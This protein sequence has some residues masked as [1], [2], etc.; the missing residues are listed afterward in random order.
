MPTNA[1]RLSRPVGFRGVFRTDRE[2]C[3]V[4]SESAGVARMIPAAVAVPLSPDDVSTLM[5]WAAANRVSLVPRG[6]GSSMGGGAVGA[7]VIV[8]LLRLDTV[9]L[10]DVNAR[11]V[12]VAAAVTRDRAE[13]AANEAGLIFPVDPSSGAFATIGGMCATNAAGARTVKYGAMRSWV[14]AVDCIFAD[15]SRARL[16]RGAAA[17]P[18]AP[19]TRFLRDVA[20]EIAKANPALLRHA[21]VRKESSGYGLAAYRESQDLVDLLIGSEGT[22]G[23]IIGAELKLAPLPAATAGVLAG[24]PDLEGAAAAAGRLA[25]A[26]ASAVELLDRSFIE[27]AASAGDPLPIAL[28]KG[29]EAVLIVEVESATEAAA[30]VAVREMRG[31]CEAGGATFVQ[32]AIEP[33][34]ASRLW[35]LR[36]AASPILNRLAPALQS[37]QV[38]EDGCVPPQHFAEY[39]RAVR[40]ALADS[41]FRGV[42]FGHAGDGHAHVNALID[43]T[44]PD[45]RSRL[46][47]LVHSVTGIVARLGGTLAGEHCDGRLRAPLLSQVWSPE[48]LH[49]FA[50]TKRAFDPDGILNPGVI[51]PAPGAKPLEDVKYDPALPPLPPSARAALDRVVREKAW[52][53]F[54]LDLLNDE[55]Q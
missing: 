16:E 48:A 10:V 29:L 40:R 19:V 26:G 8:D 54:R 28:P 49:L 43:V 50:A 35:Q 12:T 14:H 47:R 18:V 5:G 30:T 21:A 41:G 36:H 22:L 32:V 15:G 33:H 17:P 6:A 34:D 2:A 52:G 53:A 42:I 37:V 23:V 45:W 39:V 55:S 46:E 11:R 51:L 20:P 31:W 38:V 27:I 25:S 3:A 24:F 9:G 4:Y 44:E 13:L 7:G 1:E